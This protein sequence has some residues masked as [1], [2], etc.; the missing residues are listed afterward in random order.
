M[1]EPSLAQALP[2]GHRILIDSSVLI[3]YLNRT[4]QVWPVAAHVIDGFVRSGRNEA[5][6]SMVHPA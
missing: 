5:L 3:A 4:E 1:S 2:A 6:V